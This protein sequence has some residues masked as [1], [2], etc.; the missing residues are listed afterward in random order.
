MK[1]AAIAVLFVLAIAAAFAVGRMQQPSTVVQQHPEPLPDEVARAW[2]GVHGAANDPNAW[3]EL[4]DAQAAAG[5]LL[6]A[7]H[8]YLTAIRMGGDNGLAYARLGFLHYAKNEDDRAL[9]YLDEA[10]QRGAN[11]P[12]LDFTIGALK[13][14]HAEAK[15]LENTEVKRVADAGIDPPDASA[16]EDA[17]V[18][19]EPQ[20]DPEPEPEIAR[21]APPPEPIPERSLPD[22]RCSLP[23]QRIEQG[24]TYVVPIIVYGHWAHL[25]IDTGASITV[26]TE[27][28][29]DAVRLPR[30][31][32]AIVRAITANGRVDFETA[33]VPDVVLADRVARNVRVAVCDSC[34]TMADGLL[35]LDLVAAFGLR[36]DLA[37]ATIHFADCD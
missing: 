25:I 12:M 21:V 32:S 3:A 33:I 8:A 26:L 30:D 28:Y 31:P 1:R 4:G 22:G 18:P 11:V 7:E 16:E 9:A 2:A 36:L 20:V 6:G 29:A 5:D 14:G 37:N 24:R 19:I 34:E 27:R 13:S 23:V 17:A 35:G 15:P 10:K